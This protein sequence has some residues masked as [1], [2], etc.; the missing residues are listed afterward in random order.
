MRR[1]SCS[2][3]IVSLFACVVG[4]AG[5]GPARAQAA[6]DVN[7]LAGKVA[8]VHGTAGLQIR[9]S[10]FLEQEADAGDLGVNPSPQ[11]LITPTYVLSSPLDGTTVAGP[12]VTVNL[13]TAGAPQN[14]T[15]IAVDP[16]NPNRIVAAANDYVTRTWTCFINGTPCSALGDGY[17]GTYFSND[18]GEH[19]CCGS[20][21]DGSS[22]GTQI[23]GVD[24]L[25]GG[26][27][28]AGGDPS[29]AFDSRGRVYYAGLGFD[30]TAPPSTVAVN[31]GTFDAN[32]KLTWSAPTFIN[33]TTAPSTL[34]DKP[35][36]AADANP[37]SLFRDRLYV[38]WTRFIF[39][40]KTGRYV[41]SPIA[42]SF[43][44][45][46]GQSFSDPQLIVG[47]V[48]YS[49][50][51]RP[52]VGADGT[53]YVFWEGSTRLSTFDSIWMVKSSDGGNSWSKPVAVSQLVSIVPIADTAF[54]VNSY[55]AAA[56]APDGTLYVTWPSEVLDSASSY[57]VS[58]TCASSMVYADCHSS[59]VWSKSTD[60]GETWT[61][62]VPVFPAL[63]ASTRAAVGYD[64]LPSG[65]NLT[66]DTRRVDTF[67]PAVAVSP[68]GR[69]YMSAYA[70]DVVS[71]WQTCAMPAT[72]TAVGRIDCLELGSYINNARLDYVVTNLGTG[73][74]QTAT[75]H[76]VNSRY[77]FGGAFFGDYTDIAAG[78]DNTFHAFWTDS[79][80][81]QSV[82]WFYGFEFA[83]G[84]VTNQQDVV[85]RAGNF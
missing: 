34:N 20:N 73:A 27:Y 77:G 42:F 61:A 8:S 32:G 22:L 24:H 11:T 84:T 71:P 6:Y 28:D 59:A 49:Q 64:T 19:W 31:R 4:L 16:N 3:P 9:M 37:G 76:P 83:P 81:R 36:I 10:A 21:L 63:D 72:P 78:S 82:S 56:V 39:S 40:A 38:T 13:D 52:V 60:G 2:L 44:S 65:V 80:N 1:V 5:S 35:W 69:I 54:R 47:N 62:P 14:E 30:R 67:F 29:V 26:P 74:S 57:S 17:S 58:S 15:A 45:D 7:T 70:A 33:P 53:V 75:T 68:S 41:Q 48:L 79:N 23:P 50:G 25:A 43:S 51:S 12:A 55:P 66:P 46:G 18:G 85:I